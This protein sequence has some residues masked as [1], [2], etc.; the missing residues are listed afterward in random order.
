M[1]RRNTIQKQLILAVMCESGGRLTAREVFANIIK[2][3][4]GISKGTVYRNLNLLAEEGL[5]IKYADADVARFALTNE[6]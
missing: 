2:E 4:P 1:I 6:G 5:I 3:Y